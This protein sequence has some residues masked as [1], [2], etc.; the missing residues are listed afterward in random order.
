MRQNEDNHEG[1]SSLPHSMY[2]SMVHHSSK[3]EDIAHMRA[4]GEVRDDK[5]APEDALYEEH[6][7]FQT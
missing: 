4:L 3:H 6:K 7:D 2:V 1:N 5:V